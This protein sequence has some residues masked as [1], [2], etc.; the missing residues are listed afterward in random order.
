MKKVLQ[1]LALWIVFA[2]VLAY[3]MGFGLQYVRTQRSCLERGW[4]RY[5][6]DLKMTTYCI[7]TIDGTEVVRP[8][9]RTPKIEGSRPLSEVDDK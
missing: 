1:D 3:A 9:A 7:A 5:A 8:L 6:V 4:A 2:L